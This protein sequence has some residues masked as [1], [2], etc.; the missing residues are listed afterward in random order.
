MKIPLLLAA[1]LLGPC[2]A[3]RAGTPKPVDD[4]PEITSPL[5]HVRALLSLGGKAKGKTKP[6]PP[7]AD[8]QTKAVLAKI[9]WK[10]IEENALVRV[11]G[12]D[13]GY[14]PGNYLEDAEIEWRGGRLCFTG[15]DVISPQL[16]PMILQGLWTF[17]AAAQT[18]PAQAGKDLAAWGLPPVIDGRKLVSPD[19]AATYYGQMLR[20][21]YS[22]KPDA[23]QKASFERLS[24]SLDLLLH[25]RKQAFEHQAADVAQTDVDRVRLMLFA[26]PRPGETPFAF[27]PY[28]DVFSQLE[29]FKKKLEA[30]RDLAA[31]SGDAVREK[32]S[33]TAL[34]VLNTLQRQHYHSQAKLPAVPKPGRRAAAKPDDDEDSDRAETTPLASGLPLV[35]SALDRVN[36]KPLTPDQQEILIKSFP[37]GDLVWRLG[38]QNFWRQGL[39]GKDVKVGVIDGGI[40]KHSELAEAVKSRTNMTAERGKALTDDHGTHVTGIIHAL[41][42]DAQ[43]NGY[44]VFGNESGDPVLKEGADELVIKAVDQAVKD[45]NRIINLS[46]GAGSS[47]S[48]SLARKIEDYASQGIVFIVAAGNEHDKDGVESPSIASNAISVGALDGAGRAADFSSYGAAF[49]ARKL[50]SVVKTV[51]MLPGTN[52]YSTVVGPN[53]ESG[54]ELLDGTSMASPALSGISALLAQAASTANPVAFAGRLRDALTA[55]SS[56]LSLDKVPENAPFDQPFLVVKPLAALDALRQAAAPVATK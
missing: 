23:L 5:P 42:P 43:I 26:P 38:A 34:T 49:D 10:A 8:D 53:G 32:D 17:V 7:T 54:Y 18:P 9:G 56:P 44:T 48:D 45:G 51:F 50:K 2:A 24:Q 40:G 39:T 6:A 46:L 11:D 4:G 55:G 31:A 30:D 20:M 3:A 28:Q 33:A 35:L 14:V 13:K 25:A 16:L 19:G 41:A 47:P 29:G 12:A 15:G 22:Q 36:G 1:L 27:K 37:M 52:I 21:L